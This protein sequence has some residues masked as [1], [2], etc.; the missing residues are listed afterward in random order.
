MPK[1]KKEQVSEV[2]DK[3]QRSLNNPYSMSEMWRVRDNEAN[4]VPRDHITVEHVAVT[5]RTAAYDPA[6]TEVQT[7][8]VAPGTTRI[9]L[10]KVKETKTNAG[11]GRPP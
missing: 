8:V 4:R 11:R 5:V 3:Y 7:T 10:C 6:G 9:R 2:W 1:T